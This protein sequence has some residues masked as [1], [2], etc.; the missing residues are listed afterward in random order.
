[1]P[2]FTF[3]HGKPPHYAVYFIRIKKSNTTSN[4]GTLNASTIIWPFQK[5]EKMPLKKLS[6]KGHLLVVLV[7]KNMLVKS[8]L[9]IIKYYTFAKTG[10]E[11]SSN[12]K[13]NLLAIVFCEQTNGRERLAKP[14]NDRIAWHTLNCLL[15]GER[16]GE[17]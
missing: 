3:F 9:I 17:H 16:R 5:F 2:H 15:R 1:M 13:N 11:V 6:L 10:W 4:Y 8:W 12:R 14:E 7:F